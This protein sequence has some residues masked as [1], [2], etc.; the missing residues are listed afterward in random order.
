[1]IMHTLYFV[2]LVLVL[3][4]HLHLH[5][6]LPVI[7]I[8]TTTSSTMLVCMIICYAGMVVG[9]NSIIQKISAVLAW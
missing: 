2:V 3:F 5:L 8:S 7:L 1:M 9:A 4:L 6:H